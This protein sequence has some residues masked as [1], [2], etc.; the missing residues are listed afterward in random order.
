MKSEV[1]VRAEVSKPSRAL[2]YLRANGQHFI[3]PAQQLPIA[4]RVCAA[5]N[6]RMSTPSQSDQDQAMNH[7]NLYFVKPQEAAT[8]VKW[9]SGDGEDDE[10]PIEEAATPA[11]LAEMHRMAKLL[12]SLDPKLEIKPFEI[13]EEQFLALSGGERFPDTEIYAN[14]IWVNVSVTSAH[15]VGTQADALDA[16]FRKDVIAVFEQEGL[17]GIEE[18]TGRQVTAAD[19]SFRDSVNEADEPEKPPT[20]PAFFSP[21]APP[22]APS[23]P[24]LAPGEQVHKWWQ[25]WA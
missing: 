5:N 9:L 23:G 12:Q 25:F 20:P 15:T 10:T 13:C 7:M 2:R 16:A 22:P 1:S 3:G 14:H 11:Q 4:P 19:F 6:V 24:Q 17:V 18:S 21:P 8:W